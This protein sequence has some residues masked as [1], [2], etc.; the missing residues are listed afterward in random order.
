MRH[1]FPCVSVPLSLKSTGVE[2]RHKETAE[3]IREK[4]IAYRACDRAHEAISKVR[5]SGEARRAEGIHDILTKSFGSRNP[6]ALVKATIAALTQ[7]RT[8]NEVERLRGVSL[9]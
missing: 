5:Q 8:R 7:L 1:Y 9:A 2:P 3:E 6:A 4:G